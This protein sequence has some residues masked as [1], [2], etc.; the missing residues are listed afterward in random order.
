MTGPAT[1]HCGTEGELIIEDH[2]DH[3]LAAI[4]QAFGDAGQG[5]SLEPEIKALQW[6]KL[7]INLNNALNALWGGPLKA[8]L[9]QRPYRLALAAMMEEALSVTSAAGLTVKS[10]GKANFKNTLKILRMPNWVYRVIMDRIIKIDENARSSML[11]DLEGGKPSEV[12]FL[13]GEIVRLAE[14][15]AQPAPINRAVLTRINEAF[16]TSKSPKMD[17]HTLWKM[18]QGVTDS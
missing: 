7:I 15:N 16:E 17:G 8:G 9:V 10:F 14:T 18:V 5:I 6:G 12:D 2:D 11:E 4:T 1:F 13:Q 3:R